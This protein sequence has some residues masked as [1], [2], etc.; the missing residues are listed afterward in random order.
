MTPALASLIVGALACL[1][2]GMRGR[3]PS[4]DAR[5]GWLRLA[6]MVPVGGARVAWARPADAPGQLVAAGVDAVAT[7]D[8]LARARILGA[9]L[10]GLAGAA[11][12]PL[13][14]GAIVLAPMCAAL[15]ALAPERLLA[16]RA[17]RRRRRV[18][19][20][21]PDVL[22][23]LAICVE[24]GMALDP[25][26]TVASTHATGPLGDELRN[27][28]GDI[29][30][31]RP[32]PSAY[33]DLAARCG[34]AEVTGAVGALLQAEELGTPLSATL[35]AQ[36]DATREAARR[37]ALE[38][39]ARAGP[40]IQLVVAVVMVPAALILIVGAFAIELSREVGAMLGAP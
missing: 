11:T 35:A 19:A 25:A 15:G 5:P 39:A 3:R 9:V 22:D 27:A 6:A 4:P 31:G 12:T 1:S 17:A 32:R 18:R 16:R 37:Q 34:V 30:L 38:R 28:L 36:A 24:G 26:L 21:L 7:A 8:D 23:L 14:D 20:D 33:A 29:S 2:L 13:W 40:R 10:A